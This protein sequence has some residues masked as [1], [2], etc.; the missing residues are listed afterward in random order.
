M[1]TRARISKKNGQRQ[2]ERE[3]TVEK[4]CASGPTSLPA[5]KKRADKAG[6]PTAPVFVIDS[7][8]PCDDT[9]EEAK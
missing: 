3:Q 1:V 7:G 8:E 9:K 5:P 4:E 2:Y 6:A